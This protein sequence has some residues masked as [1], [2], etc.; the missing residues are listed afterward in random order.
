MVRVELNA[1]YVLHHRPFRNSSLIVELFSKL[2]GRIAA[3]ARSARGPKS[4]YKGCLQLFSPLLVAWCGRGELMTLNQMEQN[5]VPHPLDGQAL[6]CA[7]YLNELLLRL[8]P[9]EDPYPN[10]FIDYENTLADLSCNQNNPAIL[11]RRF[12]KRLLEH[13][14]YGLSF[15]IDEPEAFYQWL[16]DRGFLRTHPLQSAEHIFSGRSLLALQ[17]EKWDN[18]EDL[19]AAKRL[20]RLVLSRHLGSKPLKT[21]ELF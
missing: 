15:H 7:F 18:P 5:G 16:P 17:A 11:L 13:L 3:V 2:Y 6:M 19:I 8:M 1:V 10:F 14:G 20:M 9:P 4:R 12:E 21:R